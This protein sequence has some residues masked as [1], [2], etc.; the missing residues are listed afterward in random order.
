MKTDFKARPVYS[1]R[2]DWIKTHFLT[3][4]VALIITRLLSIRLDNQYTVSEILQTLRH[5]NLTDTAQG[6]YI[7][8]YTRTKITDS[9]HEA[10]GFR[11]D[12]EIISKKNIR[13]IIK[14]TK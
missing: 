8:S 4:F 3:C 10:F 12:D 1:Q 6:Y 9:L 14:N 2:E 13:T 11:T 5:M 7:P